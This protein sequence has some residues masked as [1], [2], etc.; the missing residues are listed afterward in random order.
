MPNNDLDK[1]VKAIDKNH[2][3]LVTKYNVLVKR[4]NSIISSLKDVNAKLEY[5]SD[6]MSMFEIIDVD[7]EDEEFDPYSVE[8]EDYEEDNDE[9]EE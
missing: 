8:R 9:D 6:K 2:N 5:L 3:L 7:V 1:L 4:T